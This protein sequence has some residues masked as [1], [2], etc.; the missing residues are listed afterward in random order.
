VRRAAAPKLGAYT[1]LAGLGL[2]AALVL[3]RP[4]LVAL[5]APFAALVALGLLTGTDPGLTFRSSLAKDR[6]IEGDVVEFEVELHS[7]RGC[8]QVELVLRL[9]DGLVIAEDTPNP[10]TIRLGRDEWRTIPFRLRVERWGGYVVGDLAVRARDTLGLFRF[11]ASFTGREQLRVFPHEE[12]LRRAVRPH[13]TQPYAGD[14]VARRR[15]DGIEFADLRPFAVGDALRRVN[16]RATARRGELWVNDRHPERNSDVVL[17]L[18][19]FAEARR[20][21]SSTLD[22]AVRAAATLTRQYVGRRD[23]IGLV[24]FGGVLRWLQPGSGMTQLYRIVDALLDTEIWLNYAWK[25]IDIVPPRTLPPQAMVVA[26]TP[27]LDERSVNAL[28]DLRS[29]GFDL[30]VIE[31][32]PLPYVQAGA[33]EREQLA[34]RIWRL[35]RDALRMRYRQAGVAVGEWRDGE[36]L[37]GPLEEVTAYRRHAVAGRG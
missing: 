4:E 25:D 23:R 5:A 12:H 6:M 31:T 24:S 2:L 22:L 37:A 15:G 16:W 14:D 33:S 35:R 9:P 19:T 10:V 28:L 29:R 1:G 21:R 18:D 34:F 17:F 3:G 20:D 8:P 13:E 27:L 26:I 30:T 36:P 11:E 32:S 7:A